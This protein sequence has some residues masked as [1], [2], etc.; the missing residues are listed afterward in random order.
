MK[1]GD[2]VLIKFGDDK[3]HMC[4]VV[5]SGDKKV[6]ILLSED[7]EVIASVQQFWR[8]SQTEEPRKTHVALAGGAPVGRGSGKVRRVCCAKGCGIVYEA[9]KS[10][11]ERGWGLCC[12]KSCAAAYRRQK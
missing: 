3:E 10:D 5:D 8:T 11:L 6:L 12:S 4:D 1:A 9:K 2:R 7:G